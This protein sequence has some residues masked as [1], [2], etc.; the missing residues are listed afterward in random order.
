VRAIFLGTPAFAVPALERL[1][2]SGFEVV[3]VVTQPDRPVGRGGNVA[4]P[5]VKEAAAR[6]GLTVFQP[7]TLRAPGV[8]AQ[9]R[10][11]SPD[12]VVVVA[13]GQI[14][15]RSLLELPPLGC[16]NVHPSLLPKLRGAAPIQG[17]IRE[18][19]TETGVSI[20]LMNERMD[21]GPVL[22]QLRCPLFANDTAATLGDRL[23]DFGA[24]LLVDTLPRWK[25]GLIEPKPQS[26]PD[27]TYSA[28]L[29]KEDAVVNWSR[30]AL[31]IARACR[32]YTP[33]PG[34]QTDWGGRP[35]RLFGLE[36]VVNAP[37]RLAPG[38]VFLLREPARS[39]GRLAIATGHMAVAPTAL[40]LPG[41]R[42]VDA[43]EFLRG[44]PSIIGVVLS[45]TSAG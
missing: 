7:A 11:V 1:V 2:S 8:L 13:Y 14:L 4:P 38:T 42:V 6:L 24:R 36:P 21:A 34:C 9:L 22:T 41:R 30:S 5:P 29:R 31:E 37:A 43:A 17:A 20:M 40:Q 33:W 32:A 18:G 19:L 35:L 44:Y 23:A 10:E 15:R 16:V 39:E 12:I 28:P 45:S 27:A 3:Q 26:E 25:A